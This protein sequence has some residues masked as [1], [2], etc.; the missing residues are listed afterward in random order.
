MDTILTEEKRKEI[1]Y[2]L[3][4]MLNTIN[5]MSNVINIYG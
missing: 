3:S 2:L 4:S 5:N 1:I